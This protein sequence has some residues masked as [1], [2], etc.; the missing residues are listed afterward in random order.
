ML[1]GAESETLKSM[2]WTA[3]D[4]LKRQRENSSRGYRQRRD[5]RSDERRQKGHSLNVSRTYLSLNPA[6]GR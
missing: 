5:H 2:L 4:R 1:N 6:P 3:A